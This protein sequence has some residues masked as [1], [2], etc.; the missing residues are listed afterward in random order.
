M[1]WSEVGCASCLDRPASVL[2]QQKQIAIDVPWVKREVL[3]E[4]RMR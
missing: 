4:S 2:G 3:S 1:R